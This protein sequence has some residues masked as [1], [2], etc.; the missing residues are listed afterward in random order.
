MLRDDFQLATPPPHPSEAPVTSTNPLST[1]IAPPTQ[2]VKLTLVRTSAS[3]APPQLYNIDSAVNFRPN[4]STFS[5]KEHEEPRVSHDS[6]SNESD[7]VSQPLSSSSNGKAPAFGA[8]NSLLTAPSI[9]KDA[10]KRKKPKTNMMK[11]NSTFISRMVPHEILSRR[12]QERDPDGIL[13]F[14]NINR[15][16]Q[17]LDLTSDS[18]FKGEHLTKV[19][20]TK[21]HMLCHNA[22]EL[23]KTPNHIDLVAGSSAGDI[24]WY[25]PFSQR[26]NRINKNG[27]INVSPVSDVKWIPG[28]ENLFLASHHDGTLIV[29]DKERDDAA[30]VAEETTQINTEPSRDHSESA[31]FHVNKSVNSKN[32]KMNPVASWKISNQKISQ[33]AFSPDCQHLAVVSNDGSLRI[34]DYLKEMW[35]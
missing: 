25:E 29:Y 27:V 8:N 13:C 32:Q 3:K 34:I 33:M 4:F 9:G 17:W 31:A 7:A 19:L 16:I 12:L 21:A 14:A 5:I 1:A 30:F 18:H 10:A 11:T 22:N 6:N 28:S 24:V 23:T 20:F 26:Y 35:V 2:G 15:A